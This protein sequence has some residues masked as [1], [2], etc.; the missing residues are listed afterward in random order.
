M[1]QITKCVARAPDRQIEVALFCRGVGDQHEKEGV[2]WH[3]SQRPLGPIEAGGEVTGRD[4][5]PRGQ[6]VR[7]SQQ[8]ERGYCSANPV[9][10]SRCL[11][12]STAFHTSRKAARSRVSSIS[13]KI[14]MRAGR[15]PRP[16]AMLISCADTRLTAR[17]S[18]AAKDAWRITRELI[19]KRQK[20]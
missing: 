1:L 7:F 2:F 8:I 15:P 3:Q 18:A 20:C 9:A 11:R 19:V 13:S 14:V 10:R 5:R 12:G 16:M 6:L 4:V 17:R